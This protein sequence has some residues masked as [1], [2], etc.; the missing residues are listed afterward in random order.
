MSD[1]ACDALRS[2]ID[3]V[4]STFRSVL[5]GMGFEG[6]HA[7]MPAFGQCT[8]SAVNDDYDGEERITGSWVDADGRQLAHFIRYANGSMFAEKDVLQPHPTQ[9]EHFVE[10]I[11]VWGRPG[12]LKHEARLLP[13]L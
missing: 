1:L 7:A 4:C 9:P 3:E 5:L 6:D 11:E 8:L 2:E 10:A 12:Q 13:A